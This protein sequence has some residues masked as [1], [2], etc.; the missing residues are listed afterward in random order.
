MAYHRT[1][2]FMDVDDLKSNFK[3]F[4]FE[5]N[6]RDKRPANTIVDEEDVYH[7]YESYK[8]SFCS[9][10]L[11][12][13]EFPE[14][15]FR[16][17]ETHSDLEFQVR[18]QLKISVMPNPGL[19]YEPFS[20]VGDFTFEEYNEESGKYGFNNYYEIGVKNFWIRESFPLKVFQC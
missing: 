6:E 16:H 3:G 14:L 2:D 7:K 20:L 10:T 15:K 17:G 4:Y 1:D 18:T 8:V 19:S 11:K 5:E 12:N 13:I 9:S